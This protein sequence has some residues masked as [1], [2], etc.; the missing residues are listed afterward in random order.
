MPATSCR[1]LPASSAMAP[2]PALYD[3]TMS[4]AVSG[5]WPSS[6]NT[7]LSTASLSGMGGWVGDRPSASGPDT[8]QPSEALAAPD[9][10]GPSKVTRILSLNSAS[11]LSTAGGRVSITMSFDS[12]SLLSFPAAGMSR[13]AVL[14]ALS[15]MLP[16]LSDRAPPW[17]RSAALSPWLTV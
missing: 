13:S 2:E 9:Q 12:A 8:A 17:S 16:S 10:T 3:S 5:R 15:V 11:A 1:M 14:P 7:M 6:T 4:G